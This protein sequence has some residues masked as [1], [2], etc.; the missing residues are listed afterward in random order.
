[1]PAATEARDALVTAI[2]EFLRSGDL[3]AV[4]D[5]RAE[6]EREIDFAGAGS[7]LGL[8]GRLVED[9]GWDYSPPDRLAQRIH[10]LLAGRFLAADSELHGIEF[11]AQVARQP[12]VTVANHLSFADA[13]VV[14]VLLQRAGAGAVADRLTAVAGPKVFTSRQRRFSSLCFGTIK[15][16]QSVEVASG[17]AVLD[18]RVVARAARQA[19]EVAHARIASGDVL[20]LFPEG[21]RSRTGAMQPMLTA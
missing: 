14:E 12:V 2:L 3:L 9:R 17:E 21:T 8:K 16:P 18:S 19:I 4:D 10:H 11:L 7:I 6:L 13:N 20:L 15:V 5:V 1:M